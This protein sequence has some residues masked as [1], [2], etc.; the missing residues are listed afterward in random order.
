MKGLLHWIATSRLQ[1]PLR[2][3]AFVHFARLAAESIVS[4]VVEILL[5][6]YLP[7]YMS[8]WTNNTLAAGD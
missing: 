2:S 6:M 4:V 1:E 5:K 7:L 8:W 3:C